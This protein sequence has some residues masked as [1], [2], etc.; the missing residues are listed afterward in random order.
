MTDIKAEH[1]TNVPLEYDYVFYILYLFIFSM[2]AC[3]V[4]YV[5][6]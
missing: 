3:N 6:P 2:L 1:F 5:I 4:Y